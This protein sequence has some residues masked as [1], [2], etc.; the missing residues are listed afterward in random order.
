MSTTDTY[1]DM[2]RTH[3]DQSREGMIILRG[4]PASGKT[5]LAHRIVRSLTAQG[6]RAI[7]I[8]R[9]DIRRILCTGEDPGQKC[10]G[11]PNAESLVTWL[12][13]NMI[14]AAFNNGIEWIIED[15]TNIY[16]HSVERLSHSATMEGITSLVIDIDV[17]VEECVAR[18]ALRKDPC[19]ED[20]IRRMATARESS[21]R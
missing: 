18:D 14:K 3:I 16:S 11:D 17:P 9:D 5:T 8:G 20:V 7:R 4:L 13:I 2:A 15:S 12:E 1:Y 21:A 10:V 6:T 19:G